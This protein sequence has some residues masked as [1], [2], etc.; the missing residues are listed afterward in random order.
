MLFR[1]DGK[2]INRCCLQFYV[3]LGHKVIIHCFQ[4]WERE[5]LYAVFYGA[6]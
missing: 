6:D 3:A 2:Y 1:L 5:S 4:F